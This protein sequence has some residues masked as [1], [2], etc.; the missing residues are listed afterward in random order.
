VR[1]SYKIL[2]MKTERTRLF[3][4]SMHRWQYNI[5][6]SS[7]KKIVCFPFSTYLVFDTTRAT[8]NT[9]RTTVL[10]LRC[11]FC[12][13]NVFTEPLP[14]NDRLFWLH[15]FSLLAGTHTQKGCLISLLFFQTKE[16]GLQVDPTR[17]GCECVD[18]I[19]VVHIGSSVGLEYTW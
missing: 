12:R 6:K 16:S 2:A 1:N 4:R 19:R 17:I 13:G 18:C 10:L 15:C 9:P 11:I 8:Q 14:S 7:G 5:T 3:G